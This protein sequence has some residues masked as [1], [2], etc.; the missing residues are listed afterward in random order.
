MKRVT[1]IIN[2][3]SPLKIGHRFHQYFGSFFCAFLYCLMSV[4]S[5]PLQGRAE[6]PSPTSSPQK[7]LEGDVADSPPQEKTDTAASSPQERAPT[8]ELLKANSQG[9][10]EDSEGDEDNEGDDFLDGPIGADLFEA[11][12]REPTPQDQKETPQ[13][14]DQDKKSPQR[15]ADTQPAP[16]TP[17]ASRRAQTKSLP[18]KG[19][20]EKESGEKESGE[21]VLLDTV[22]IIGSA[23]RISRVS[24]SAHQVKEEELE[25]QNYDDVHRVLKQVPGV[26]V[27]DEDGLGLR[28]NI[29]LRGANSDRSAKVT[30]MEDGVLMAPAPYSAPAAYYFPLT[31]R[32]TTVEV[33]KG[34]ASI[35]YGPNTLGGAL[36]MV[37]RSAPLNGHQGGIDASWGQFNTGKLHT[38]YGWGG[39]NIGFVLEGI[40]LQ[41]DGFKELDNGGDTGFLKR[42]AMFK[43]RVNSN[44]NADIFHRAELKLGWATEISNET[45]LGLTD[46]DF[47]K[48]PYRRYA[49]SQLAEMTWQRL[50]GKLDYD[51]S[52]GD[53]WETKLIIYRHQFSRAWE[54]VIGFNNL[55]LISLEDVLAD[56]TS[57]A[58]RTLYGVLTGTQDSID[59]SDQLLLGL[60]DRRYL[61]QGVQ[62]KTN[63]RAGGEGWEN[64]LQLGARLHYDRIDRDHSQRE[65]TMTQ[66][67]LEP[68]GASTTA[69][70]NRG[71]TTAISAYLFDELK[72][73]DRWRITP[74]LR[75][76][77]YETQLEDLRDTGGDVIEGDD[78][79]LLPGLGAW[80]TLNDHWGFLGG[81][82]RGFAP[83]ALSQTGRA[84][85]E[86]SINYEVGA[87]WEYSRLR[88]EMIAFYNDYQ[89][90]VGVCTQSA[91]CPVSRLDEQINAGRASVLGLEW[92]S[93]VDAR[94]GAWGL[95]DGGLTYTYTRGRFSESFLSD[96][97]QWGEVN[98]GDALPY[99]PEHQVNLKATLSDSSRRFGGGLSY[100]IVG[101]MLDSA[102][103]LG[104]S[105]TDI[106]TQHILDAHTYAEL[107]TDLRVYLTVDNVLNQ[108]YR[109]A[110]RPF[111]VRPSKPFLAQIGIRYQF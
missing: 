82:H 81:V 60:N 41:S 107:L 79:A 49:A 16:E 22:S 62:L 90:L 105:D 111:G 67:V 12:D 109:V 94:L 14:A 25:A 40:Q 59:M 31:T 91:G 58:N 38:H 83:L 88:G 75:V 9:D 51:F 87:R 103:I 39:E 30:L 13:G 70:R 102:G 21:S 24:G 10:A 17:S 36:N 69:V 56:P 77:R 53:N 95:L 43:L 23:E 80:F 71:E 42:E 92:V 55:G 61:S 57:P 29:G 44:P 1:S 52:I 32:L 3:A 7:I 76:E 27:R 65:A 6:P 4:L 93:H 89:N 68:V 34:P 85:P 20:G 110:R 74:G 98:K 35:Q 26:Y 101:P 46:T 11:P 73:G 8:P 86:V 72:L 18:Q 99:V 2:H 45:Y 106:P 5:S 104:E 48:T 97:A 54:K 47:E 50:Q 64:E 96:F 28:P 37:T 78:W 108:T 33:F 15:E 100:T 63:W 84:D 19:S 66:G